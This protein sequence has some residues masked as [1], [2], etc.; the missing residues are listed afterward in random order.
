MLHVFAITNRESQEMTVAA[1]SMTNAI[2]AA[3]QNRDQPTA[4]NFALDNIDKA[5]LL[6][7]IDLLD[8]AGVKEALESFM[9]ERVETLVEE[10]IASLS[11]PS[12]KRK[13]A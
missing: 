9:S 12:R 2:E 8:N 13:A 11:R 7:R 5:E 1:L 10:R 3:G 6:V 4:G